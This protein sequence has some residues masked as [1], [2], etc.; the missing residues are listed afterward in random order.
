MFDRELNPE[1]LNKIMSVIVD[2]Q[3][4]LSDDYEKTNNA[5]FQEKIYQQINLIKLEDFSV[6]PLE[7][8]RQKQEKKLGRKLLEEENNKIGEKLNIN[9]METNLVN[10][11]VPKPEE[12]GESSRRNT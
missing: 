1:E 5:Q 12:W 3:W 4:I 11:V 10:N 2:K 6:L 9:E 7:E 8:I